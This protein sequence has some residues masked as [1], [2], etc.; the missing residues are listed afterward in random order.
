VSIDALPGVSLEPL[1][2]VEDGGTGEQITVGI[3]VDGYDL[4][5]AYGEAA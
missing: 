1:M 2:R 5:V 4:A 3:V